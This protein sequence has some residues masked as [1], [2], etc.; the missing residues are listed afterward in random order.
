MR[1]QEDVLQIRDSINQNGLKHDKKTGAV[2][3]GLTQWRGTL[4]EYFFGN[5]GIPHIFGPL[6]AG[7]ARSLIVIHCEKTKPVRPV[8]SH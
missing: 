3:F 7:T 8:H 6:G 2:Q 4:S 1:A 5:Q